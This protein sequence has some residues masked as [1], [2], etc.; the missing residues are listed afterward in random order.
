MEGREEPNTINILIM[1]L[2]ACDAVP[3]TGIEE[4][5]N[6]HYP[7]EA[8]VEDPNIPASSFLGLNK[9]RLRASE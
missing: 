9:S 8:D 1:F 6:F 2:A 4:Y 5:K 3:V 7:H